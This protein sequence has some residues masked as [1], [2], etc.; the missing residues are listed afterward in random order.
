[1]TDTKHT[2]GPWLMSG[3]DFCG[4][5]EITGPGDGP[6]IAR[7]VGGMKRCQEEMRATAILLKSAPGLL[8][9]MKII[10]DEYELFADPDDDA[11]LAALDFADTI[12]A[13]AE[14]RE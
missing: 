3:P 2:P 14:G 8:R 12:I 4:D 1:M 9:A 11:A 10:R 13:K 7:V 5:Y 6:V